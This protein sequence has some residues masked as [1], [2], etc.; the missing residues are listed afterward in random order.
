MRRLHRAAT[1]HW[2]SMRA[3]LPI[4]RRMIVLA[5]VAAFGGVLFLPVLAAG[6]HQ[7]IGTVAGFAVVVTIVATL[8]AWP[9][10]RCSDLAD[11]PMPFLRR[12][13]GV[14]A[15]APPRGFGVSLVWGAI[16]GVGSAI[17]FRVI[18]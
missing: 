18:H 14:V 1:H 16:L 13:D 8:A 17:A 10:L 2:I 6:S 9:G 5:A 15:V 3:Q 7:A 12:L 4:R 11:L